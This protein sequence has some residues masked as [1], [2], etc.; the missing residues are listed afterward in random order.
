MFHIHL[1]LVN[2]Y[3]RKDPR[4]KAEYSVATYQKALFVEEVIYILTL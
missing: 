2:R 4:L 3:Q 1:K